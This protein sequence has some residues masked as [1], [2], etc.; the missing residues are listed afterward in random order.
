MSEAHQ[1]QQ[2]RRMWKKEIKF[3]QREQTRLLYEVE[4]LAA[5]PQRLRE[6]SKHLG[7]PV[8]YIPIMSKH[9]GM[10]EARKH[11]SRISDLQHLLNRFKV[12]ES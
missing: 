7:R 5:H 6:L 4:Y 2:I 9:N 11:Q 3:S 12:N 1:Y 8:T 10:M